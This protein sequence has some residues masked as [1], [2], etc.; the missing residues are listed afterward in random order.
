MNYITQLREEN[1]ALTAQLNAANEECTRLMTMLEGSKYTTGPDTTI[2]AA[3]ISNR[4][5]DLRSLT[6]V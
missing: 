2:Q 4:I 6:L 1:A 5:R 3:E